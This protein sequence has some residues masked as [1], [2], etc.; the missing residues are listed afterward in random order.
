M[1]INNTE[2]EYTLNL[3]HPIPNTFGIKALA[4]VYAE[5]YSENAL[6]EILRLHEYAHMPILHIGEGSNLLFLSNYPGI[7]LRSRIKSI[8]VLYSDAESVQVRVGGG[9]NFDSFIAYAL[10]QGWYGLENLS[11]IP[12]QVGASAVQNIGAYGVEA[13]DFIHRVEGISLTDGSTRQWEAAECNYAY[14]QSIFKQQ[15]K[16]Q[17][18]ITY[19]TFRLHRTFQPQLFY[20]GIARA[21]EQAGYTESTL[22]AEQLRKVI[23]DVRAKKLPNPSEQGSAGSFYMNPV[24]SMS[25]FQSIQRLYPAMPYYEI[26]PEAVKIPA[27]WLIEQCGWKGRAL[28]KAAVHHNQA[29]VLVNI[30][31]AE[32]KDILQLSNAVS[33]DVQEKFD[34]ILQPEVNFIGQVV[35]E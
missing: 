11:D 28:G 20:G 18:A 34:I 33:H 22:T 16:G 25:R 23:M 3:Q 24:V 31:D 35:E 2:K 14:R 6:R 32:G 15:L 10:S 21:V 26:G 27:G 1:T 4:A 9:E 19:V 7:V 29:L 17:Y 12:G 8:E 13:K 5:Y 30:G